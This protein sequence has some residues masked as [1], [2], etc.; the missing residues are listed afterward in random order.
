MAEQ[1]ESHNSFSEIT[2]NIANITKKLS[3][4]FS[5]VINKAKE[6]INTMLWTEIFEVTEQTNQALWNLQNEILGLTDS[7]LSNEN[8]SDNERK[9]IDLLLKDEKINDWFSNWLNDDSIDENTKTKEKEILLRLVKKYANNDSNNEKWD[10]EETEL[11]EIIS[12]FESKKKTLD[13]VLE[14]ETIKNRDPKITKKQVLDKYN[15]LQWDDNT[16][17]ISKQD[18]IDSFKTETS[19]DDN[20]WNEWSDWDNWNNWNDNNGNN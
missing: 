7:E 20:N 12:L 11:N 5:E 14:D 10:L 15:E 2:E 9:I 19:D 17:N 6:T 4:F 18:I 13:E 3:D 16:K 8:I 1:A